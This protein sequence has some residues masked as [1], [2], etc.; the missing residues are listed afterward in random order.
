MELTNPSRLKS[1]TFDLLARLPMLCGSPCAE[2]SSLDYQAEIEA[3]FAAMCALVGSE[4]YSVTAESWRHLAAL[5]K[6]SAQI[7]GRQEIAVQRFHRKLAGVLGTACHPRSPT[8]DP[9]ASPS[10]PRRTRIT[11]PSPSICSP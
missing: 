10:A 5:P 6:G 8:I 3:T 4:D 7:Y 11:M 1:L 9:P 2:A